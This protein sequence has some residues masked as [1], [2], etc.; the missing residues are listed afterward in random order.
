MITTY[1]DLVEQ[2]VKRLATFKTEE[3]EQFTGISSKTIRKSM[4]H[5]RGIMTEVSTHLAPSLRFSKMNIWI[6]ERIS[7]ETIM[8]ELGYEMNLSKS[9]LAEHV[10]VLEKESNLVH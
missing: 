1:W 8:N 2:E 10:W 6:E 5:F 3:Y 9:D 4:V 7:I